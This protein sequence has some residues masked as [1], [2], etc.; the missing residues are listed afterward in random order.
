ME[1]NQNEGYP[2][3]PSVH[4]SS[5]SSH[6]IHPT[7]MYT[8]Q[9]QTRRMYTYRNPPPPLHFSSQP[10]QV[11]ERDIFSL[12]D[13]VSYENTAYH[14]QMNIPQGSRSV[15]ERNRHTFTPPRSLQPLIG[16]IPL[17]VKDHIFGFLPTD[18]V[19]HA[20]HVSKE[21]NQVGQDRLSYDIKNIILTSFEKET[22]MHLDPTRTTIPYQY[23]TD[24]GFAK[25]FNA[26]MKRIF[27]NTGREW[28]YQYSYS[29]RHDISSTKRADYDIV[30]KTIRLYQDYEREIGTMT[31]RTMTFH[32][33]PTYSLKVERVEIRLESKKYEIIHLELFLKTLKMMQQTLDIPIDIFMD[34]KPLT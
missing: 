4:I 12:R 5:P 7:T 6:M 24:F 16:N 17:E 18:D 14:T 3:P 31:F 30:Y 2:V 15:Y 1:V 9:H 25:S 26:A 34:G 13:R 23:Y 20:S 21:W 8:P 33:H 32:Y 11:I 10:R 19:I 28:I 27:D 29:I 22:M